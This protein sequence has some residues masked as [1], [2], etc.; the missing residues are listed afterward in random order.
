MP[1]SFQRG[2]KG[3]KESKGFS[4]PSWVIYTNL[5]H[6]C[7]SEVS[8]ISVVIPLQTN[9]DVITVYSN[10]LK[11]LSPFEKKEKVQLAVTDFLHSYWDTS[12]A[13]KK[14]NLKA[15]AVRYGMKSIA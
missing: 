13:K 7:L 11:A 2:R 8:F 9:E 12:K 14:K 15:L 5:K 1:A 3:P 4:R 10:R 6:V